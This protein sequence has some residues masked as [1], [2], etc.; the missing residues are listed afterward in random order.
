M[1]E[2]VG[3]VG[4]VLVTGGTGFIGT[5]LSERLLAQGGRVSVLTRDRERATRHFAGRVAA[6]QS[7]EEIDSADPPAV[8]VNLAGKSLGDERWND[9]VKQELVSSR[10]KTTQQ[11]VDYI[12]RAADKPRLLIS[13]SA[14]GYYGA[15]GEAPLTEADPPGDEFQSE[16]CLRWEQA[17]EKAAQYGVRVCI[18]RTGV[19]MGQ[20]GGALSGLAPLFSLGLGAVAGSGRQW[21]SWVH[22][23]DLLEMFLRFMQDES[24]SG[25]FNNTAPAPVTNRQFAKAIGRVMH[26]P[27]L[28]RSPGWAML[29]L[30][31]EM[32][33]LYLT[34]QRVLPTRHMEAGFHYRFP[35]IESALRQAL[36]E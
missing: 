10:V 3:N 13:G 29:L 6:L 19:V 15:R 26:R 2:T 17:A 23:E 31:G 5:A 34:G 1:N 24:L 20:G 27:V 7:M 35:D 9:K 12:A 36:A 8:I 4:H 28:L 18:S 32:A 11:V 21:L 22:M 25:A 33:H 30:Y 16:L 14:V